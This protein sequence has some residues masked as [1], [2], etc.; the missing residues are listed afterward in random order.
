MYLA[1][2]LNLKP[3][4]EWSDHIVHCAVKTKGF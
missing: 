3:S 2:L 1:L 4:G